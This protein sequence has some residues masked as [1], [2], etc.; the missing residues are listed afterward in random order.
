MRPILMTL[1][2]VLSLLPGAHAFGE[3]ARTIN[4]R[5]FWGGTKPVVWSLRGGQAPREIPTVSPEASARWEASQTK[6]AV[7]P[8]LAERERRARN[9][10]VAPESSTAVAQCWGMK[11]AMWT[12]SRCGEESRE[13]GAASSRP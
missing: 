1:L 10:E 8:L 13:V 4:P 6:P 3:E 7:R 5:E 2:S 12:L 11:P 9:A